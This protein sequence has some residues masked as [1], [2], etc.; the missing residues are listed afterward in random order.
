M[1]ARLTLQSL[2]V[3]RGERLLFEGLDLELNAG[4]AVVLVGPNGVGKTSLLRAVAGFIAPLSGEVRFAGPAGEIEPAQAR[5]EDCHLIGHQ[6]GLKSGRTAREELIFW[7][8]WTGA[9]RHAAL[10]A[11]ERL[12]VE[13]ALDLEVRKLSAGQKRRLALARLMAAKRSLWLLDEP[14]A[15]L[16]AAARA[17]F[18][19]MMAEHLAAGGLILAAAH[20]PLAVDA[21]RLEL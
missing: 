15:P 1:I 7:A 2:A 5:R 8:L 11:A 14:I 10:A 18:G 13:R 9:E 21:R 12:G 6:D 17:L 16:D 20:D 4:E 19:A 3:Q